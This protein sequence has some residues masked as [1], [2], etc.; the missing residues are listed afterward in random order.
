MTA[1]ALGGSRAYADPY[2]KFTWISPR[3]TLEVMDDFGFWMGKKLGYF[4]GLEVVPD[5]QPGPSDGTATKR[6]PSR[7]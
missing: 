5:M 3:G 7:R 6:S 1:T 2:S 4:D